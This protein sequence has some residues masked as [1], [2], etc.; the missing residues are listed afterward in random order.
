MAAFFRN[1]LV[2]LMVMAILLVRYATTGSMFG[3]SVRRPPP[4]PATGDLAAH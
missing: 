3:G 4:L 2:A 1:R